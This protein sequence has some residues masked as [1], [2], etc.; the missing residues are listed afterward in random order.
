[1]SEILATTTKQILIRN[2]RT[3]TVGISSAHIEERGL[4]KFK[5]NRIVWRQMCQTKIGPSYLAG[6]SEWMAGQNLEEMA[7]VIK[8]YKRLQI[9][10]SPEHQHPKGHAHAW[11][12]RPKPIKI[13]QCNRLSRHLNLVILFS[14][15]LSII[16]KFYASPKIW[17]TD[18][19]F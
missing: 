7:K 5:T 10:G 17:Y 4:R 19:L 9:L 15:Q 8:W 11:K 6:L 3:I 14:F 12:R 1:M 13:I 16:I 2:I 18:H